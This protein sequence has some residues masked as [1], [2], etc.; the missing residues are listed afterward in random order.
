MLPVSQAAGAT[1]GGGVAVTVFKQGQTTDMVP[2]IELIAPA[3]RE[4]PSPSHGR[5]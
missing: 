1:E 3:A 2:Q 4:T 5:N